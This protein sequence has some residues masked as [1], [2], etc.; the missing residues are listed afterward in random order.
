MSKVTTVSLFKSGR[1]HQVVSGPKEYVIDPTLAAWVGDYAVGGLDDT[2]WFYGG[3]ARKRQACPAKV[4][5]MTLR[6]IRPGSTIMIEG[7]QYECAEGGEVELSFQFPG[8]YEVT[9]TRWP[10]LDGRYTIENPPSAE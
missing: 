7:R 1:F 3:R 5:G 8:T 9:V 2:W 6:G 4:D 10:Y